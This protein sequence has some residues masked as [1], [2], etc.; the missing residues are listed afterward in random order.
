MYVF[1]IH[2]GTICARASVLASISWDFFFWS[3][4]HLHFQMYK[5]KST[6]IK[7]RNNQRC[8][9][10][11]SWLN[12]HEVWLHA[13]KLT[14]HLFAPTR[15]SISPS[16]PKVIAQDV[17]NESANKPYKHKIY[18]LKF[19]FKILERYSC[20]NCKQ[21][22]ARINYSVIHEKN[23]RV[24][25]IFCLFPSDERPDCFGNDLTRRPQGAATRIYPKYKTLTKC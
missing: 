23:W 13:W 7:Y 11:H 8:P 1:V 14:R 12:G 15:N 6:S 19:L 16:D 21:K 9:F 22:N 3:V 25:F 4:N 2:N 10:S 17:H 18:N 24:H 20:F 5:K